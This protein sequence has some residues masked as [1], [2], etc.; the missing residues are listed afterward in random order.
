MLT[1]ALP[2]LGDG[3]GD[4]VVEGGEG[5]DVGEHCCRIQERVSRI[6]M[7]LSL[8]G[9]DMHHGCIL[10]T[11]QIYGVR[12]RHTAVQ[13]PRRIRVPYERTRARTSLRA[14]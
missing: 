11:V 8:F 1:G 5:A 6:F 9:E 10:R 3:R 12:I 14:S 4:V 13:V 7:K 2:V